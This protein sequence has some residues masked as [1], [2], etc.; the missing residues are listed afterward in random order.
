MKRPTPG[1]ASSARAQTFADAV[2][3]NGARASVAILRPTVDALLT[4]IMTA[5]SPEDAHGKLIEFYRRAPPLRELQHVIANARVLAKL[6]GLASHAEANAE[7]DAALGNHIAGD[8]A[9]SQKVI[10]HHHLSE[11][12]PPAAPSAARFSLG[13]DHT[14]GVVAID[15]D[16]P[17]GPGGE[18]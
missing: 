9:R 10:F 13:H 15:L 17:L 11:V 16:L 14:N 1:G 3:L 7:I 4:L 8:P 6:A 2:A 5:T 12:L 18:P